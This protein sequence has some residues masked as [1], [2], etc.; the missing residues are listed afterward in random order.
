M[1]KYDIYICYSRKDQMVVMELRDYLDS[2]GISFWIDDM[3]ITSGEAFADQI[4]K[5]IND[6]KLFLFIAS[7]NSY[8]SKFCINE[9]YYAVNRGKP[10][11]CLLADKTEMPSKVELLLAK[12]QCIDYSN[13]QWRVSLTQFVRDFNNEEKD[14]SH[15]VL[16]TKQNWI[17]RRVSEESKDALLKLACNKYCDVLIDGEFKCKIKE[18]EII[19]IPIDF[20]S[21]IISFSDCNSENSKTL[22]VDVMQGSPSKAIV[23][24]FDN[25]EDDNHHRK[26]IKCFIAGSKRL[27][28]ERD[29]MRAVVSNM[30]VKWKSRNFLIETYSFD[31]FNHTV[32]EI[33]HQEE[34]NQ[35]I[36]TEADLVLFLF[37]NEVGD[38]TLKE[39]DIAIHSYK[40]KKHPQIIIYSR[41]TRY[42]SPVIISI[43]DRLSKEDAYWVYY[44]SIEDL[45]TKFEMDL[46]DYLFSQFKLKEM[47]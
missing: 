28:P 7:E 41:I 44:Q 3:D 42:E 32:S 36:K 26:E 27:M 23:V 15:I 19:Q 46:N 8:N 10:V 47:T 6:S 34:Y 31:N 4:I 16:E 37:D 1:N 11:F 30:Y 33:G 39:L 40:L 17:S 5:S 13:N 43:K 24:E 21:Y 18:K 20:G 9:L 25:I 12:Y 38:I 35:F 22:A 45:A 2:T 29:K 14:S